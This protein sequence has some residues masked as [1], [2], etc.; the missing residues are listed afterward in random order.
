MTHDFREIRDR[1]EKEFAEMLG[2]DLKAN[3]ADRVHIV[4]VSETDLATCGE[5]AGMTSPHIHR[6]LRSYVAR[7]NGPS[8]AMLIDDATIL[9]DCGTWW[10][11]ESRFVAVAAH[12]FSHIVCTP[13]LLLATTSNPTHWMT[14]RKDCSGN[15]WRAVRPFIHRR[16]RSYH[17]VV[18]T[19]G[20]SFGRVFTSAIVLN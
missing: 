10:D 8:P 4:L 9:T 11:T 14:V 18:I 16:W 19:S 6:W 15:R 13:G 1:I 12:E 17:R 5:F 7:W 3:G 20:H 2:P